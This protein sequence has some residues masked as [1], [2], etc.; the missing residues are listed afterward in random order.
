MALDI[1][2]GE[3]SLFWKAGIDTTDFDE[4]LQKIT[5]A[6]QLSLKKQVELQ[7][8]AG[9]TQKQLAQS[10]LQSA[11]ALEG[12]DAGFGR[13]VQNLSSFSGQ[14]GRV[15][16]SI[17]QGVGAI[18]QQVAT[19]RGQTIEL[20][21]KGLD[22]APLIS[23][24][25]TLEAE[26]E[27]VKK[28]KIE[29]TAGKVDVSAL[30]SA[31]QNV[32]TE[33]D[34]L[35]TTPLK[36]QVDTSGLK[37][38]PPVFSQASIDAFRQVKPLITD[39]IASY[40][41]LQLGATQS[42]DAIER[43]MTDL[44]SH[45]VELR[46]KGV[47]TSALD[48]SLTRI[49]TEIDSIKGQTIDVKTGNVDLSP[50]SRAL[51]TVGEQAQALSREKVELSIGGIN[52]A[53]ISKAFDE[54]QGKIEALNNAQLN[55]KVKGVD[56]TSL[57]A[58]IEKAKLQF[59]NLKGLTLH[60]TADLD[61]VQFQRQYQVL[62]QR[63]SQLENEKITLKAAGIDTRELERSI[64]EVR[65]Q[66]ASISREVLRVRVDDSSLKV[67]EDRLRSLEAQSIELKAKGVDTT[68]I[69][70]AL[71]K[72]QAKVDEINAKPVELRTGTVNLAP[73][74]QA[75]ATISRQVETVSGQSLNLK[76]GSIDTASVSKAIVDVQEKLGRLSGSSFELRLNGVDTSAV[77]AA[78]QRVQT[79]LSSLDKLS[80]HASA[81][82]DITAF[83]QSYTTLQTE[84]NG[85]EKT[86]IEL[87]AKGIDTTP[88]DRD[89]T[90]LRERLQQLSTGTLK[91]NVDSTNL[92]A[93]QQQLAALENT[94]VELKA[95]G[96]DASA[97]TASIE[98]IRRQIESLN[99]EPI[100]VKAAPVDLSS[101]EAGLKEVQAE[102]DK[103][104]AAGL[105]LKVEGVDDDSLRT[106]FD[107]LQNKIEALKT[108][109][110]S[111]KIGE[112]DTTSLSASLESAKKKLEQLQGFTITG[113]ADLN[114]EKFQ[115]AYK[116]LQ[117]EI[118]SLEQQTIQLKAAGLDTS[119]V[120]ADIKRL[121]EALVLPPVDVP[122]KTGSLKEKTTELDALK[123]KFAELSEVD[124]DSDIGKGLVTNIQRVEG[125]I[126]K[127]NSA[128]L[129]VE[130][131]AAG[132]LNEKV[133]Q[134]QKLK[135]EWAALSE[136]DRNS[137][138]GQS[139]AQNI[140]NL[141]RDVQNINKEFEKTNSL[142]KQAGAAIGTY[143][144][145]QAGSNFIQDIVQVRGEF[146]QLDVAFRTML[147]S[148]EKADKLTSEIVQLAATTPFTL[149]EVATGSKQLLAY[150]FAADD[151]T[152]TLKM[153][154]DVA[155]GVSTD[156]GG[157]VYLYGTLKTSGRVTII[158]L[159]QFAGRGVPI[160]EQLAKQ[161]GVTVTSIRDLVSAGKIGFPEVEKAFQSLTG[162]GGMFFN[163]MEQQSK[164]LTG[165]ISNLSDAWSRM[166]N[167]IGKSNEGEFAG[168]IGTATSLVNNYKDVLR[169]LEV[170]VITYGSYRAAII[171][172]TAVQRIQAEVQLQTALAGQRLSVAQGLM[173]ATSVIAQRGMAALNAVV[174]ANPFALVAAG[175]TLLIGTLTFLRDKSLDVMSATERMNEA[176]KNAS[177]TFTKQAA[178][179][180]QYVE[181]LKDQ[182]IA[183]S[184]RLNAYEKLKQIAPDIIGQLGFQAAKTTDL[185]NATNTYIA[186][187]R[188]RILLE[189][190]Q[191]QYAEALAKRDELF[192]KA[193][194][195]I[196]KDGKANDGGFLD[197]LNPLSNSNLQKSQG[198]M[199]IEAYKKAADVVVELQGEL[200]NSIGGTKE[201]LA[202]QIQSLKDQNKVLDAN[203]KAYKD[204]EDQI[205]SLNKS[206]Q[207]LSATKTEVSKTNKQLIDAASSIDALDAVRKKIEETYKSNSQKA[208]ALQ[209]DALQQQLAADLRYADARK[210]I[211]DPYS[212]DKSSAKAA[213]GIENKTNELLQQRKTLLE[214]I[215]N[216]QRDA[217]QTGLL[218]QQ[219]EIDN[220]NQKY[221]VMLQKI[222]DFNAKV[223]QT[224]QSKGTNAQGIGQVEIDKITAARNLE[225]SN[226]VQRQEAE[227]FKSNL[228]QQKKIFE[229]FE[230]AKLQFGTQKA[231][232]LFLNQTQGF[233]SYIDK[234]KA[235]LESLQ[236]D[237]SIGGR[238]KKQSV[239]AALTTAVQDQQQRN[240]QQEIKNF[241][242]LFNAAATY[243]Q[244]RTAIDEKY[245][246]LRQ[247]L[248]SQITKLTKEEYDAQNRAL[249]SAKE[250][251]VETL[252]NTL[253]QES[254]LY[255][256]LNQNI[257]G[258]SRDQIK[259]QIDSLKE[260]LKSGVFTNAD[261]EEVKLPPELMRQVREYIKTLQ[262][263]YND[264]SEFLG[265]SVE[266]L[267][268]WAK[269]FG[270]V[271][272]DAQALSQ[273]FDG[274][275]DEL[276]ATL[277]AL[278]DIANVA[279]D[280]ISAIAS[281]ASGNII[282]GIASTIKA[283][284]GVFTIGKKSR[285]S[286]QKALEEVAAFNLK[287]LAGEIAITEEVRNRQREQVKLNKL[288]I[289]G[290]Q[291]EQKLLLQQKTAVTQ[292][293]QDILSQLQQQ[294]AVVGETTEKYGGFLG[295]GRKTRVKEIT[296]SLAGKSFEE[297]E[298]LFSKGEL[299]GKAKD[300]FEMLQKLKQEGADIDQMLEENKQKA[301][302]IF[303]GTTADSIVD[304]IADGFK[305]GLRSAAD[306]ADNFQQ[307]MQQA[308]IQSLKVRVLEGPLKELFDQFADATQSGDQLT[309]SEVADLQAK[310]NAIIND[311]G[312]KFD[313]LQQ[314]AGI[315][316]SST[317]APGNS[318]SGAI[319]GMTEQQAELLAG[320]FGGLRLTAADQ[321]R[322]AMQSLTILQ[323]IES[324]TA[325]ALTELVKHSGYW[326]DVTNGTKAIKVK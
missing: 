142:V 40:K 10:I 280:A 199:D 127:V 58:S 292:Q 63:L 263:F 241:T 291:D 218:K 162:S 313:Q 303:T 219:S 82:M 167:D 213:Q 34:K 123:Q 67:V 118:N 91:V 277:E 149:Q 20:K 16:E 122:I 100:T 285:E 99:A 220:I 194:P 129:K 266:T 206:L 305:N 170:L 315:N 300:L 250:K 72:V 39:A 227:A 88:I 154:G 130:Q 274:V 198:Q 14:V 289:Q 253:I 21:A 61:L 53:S 32:Q 234:L 306:F 257:L 150:G 189:S 38:L 270:E 85:L 260:Q 7:T 134:L 22:T 202:F 275:N 102:F 255:K 246:R 1:S 191:S 259:Q 57:T 287:V 87:K 106:A 11:G 144:T 110:V 59:E 304:S 101:L 179:I 24:L 145:F 148:K 256:K 47:D 147:Q 269:I 168:A 13:Q 212:T 193:K 214:E 258:F 9:S 152:N 293:Y 200:K 314:I 320:Q 114:D 46:A 187:L 64:T 107:N 125:E 195:F 141:D 221:D 297:L 247:T 302:E 79:E 113:T 146:Q 177:D 156:L 143:L 2:G 112:V 45:S 73:L 222:K 243:D 42:L 183:E 185:T 90:A 298:A 25:E 204:N 8:Q 166:L 97:L 95:G 18:S 311:A 80:L 29:I 188:Q 89:L 104:S 272:N 182:N 276:S 94:A 281:F 96:L 69:T 176:Q 261:G 138:V 124:R 111:L 19:L 238:L 165:Q 26:V 163:L 66:A 211:L 248:N 203:S 155:A 242:D 30:T 288:K 231:T 70:S 74:S 235:E 208:T 68:A 239:Q 60:G 216:V 209:K 244:K 41:A 323:G 105:K 282:G 116:E 121:R 312:K 178:E 55:L 4:G 309:A 273:A 75:L 316:L 326:A 3:G 317:S 310:Y 169:I 295:I 254:A 224:N 158:D 294:Q 54:L 225:L 249:T 78:V 175:V 296:E 181:V 278:G 135:A 12:I 308:L 140:H 84:V 174:M 44:Q 119:E 28:G 77:D 232:E 15:S 318:L 161:M 267:N 71:A 139:L 228:E 290:L 48:Q 153:L 201:A 233:A 207:S 56:T 49:R 83:Q 279:Q 37:E 108:A 264:T 76:V 283:I 284:A 268:K 319:K 126:E 35:N 190:R 132:S 251:E 109:A 230:N 120:E 151:L 173:A 321:L 205:N 324:N 171:A 237:D 197:I 31:I 5:D 92:A 65:T 196:G 240:A 160:F 157:L 36:L 27:K 98:D 217:K 245:G 229:E 43:R 192:A 86:I 17:A 325:A 52:T 186:S 159:Q 223:A 93:L 265:V 215:A 23:S 128:F 307:L 131:T 210:K 299:T 236:L 180:K 164:T 51:Q 33:Y 301:A 133:S 137:R 226:T 136:I 62:Q 103:A 172:T 184:T 286:E 252:E 115:A 117:S 322:V 81:D 50:L 262:A 271:A 6:V